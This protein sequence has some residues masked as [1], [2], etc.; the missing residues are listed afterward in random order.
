[1]VLQEVE[2][3]IPRSHTLN[4]LLSSGYYTYLVKI[5]LFSGDCCEVHPLQVQ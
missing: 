4:M 1:M 3:Y 2:M 5:L